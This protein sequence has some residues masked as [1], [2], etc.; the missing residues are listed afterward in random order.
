VEKLSELQFRQNR[1]SGDANCCSDHNFRLTARCYLPSSQQG[2]EVV[3]MELPHWLMAG[4]ALLLVVGFIGSVL[5]KNVQLTSDQDGRE[6]NQTTEAQ[7]PAN[8]TSEA[9]AS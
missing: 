3:L 9:A 1:L 5:Q 4:G 6:D 2:S 7:T 8:P